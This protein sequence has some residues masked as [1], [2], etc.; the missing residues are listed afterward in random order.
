MIRHRANFQT[1]ARLGS[2][3][4]DSPVIDVLSDFLDLTSD[5]A[6]SGDF[7]QTRDRKPELCWVRG[8]DISDEER[9]NCLFLDAVALDLLGF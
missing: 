9:N 4:G 5:Q 8:G 1:L 6:Q 7:L 2:V 3:T